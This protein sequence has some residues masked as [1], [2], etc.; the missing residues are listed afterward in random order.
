M[1]LAL[2]VKGLPQFCSPNLPAFF[3]PQHHHHNCCINFPTT[4]IAN[5]PS[6]YEKLSDND[7]KDECKRKKIVAYAKVTRPDMIV[8]L[9]DYDYHRQ[10]KKLSSKR[11][12]Y[13]HDDPQGERELE[14]INAENALRRTYTKNVWSS[15]IE[16]Y[17][18]K[19]KKA[20][21]GLKLNMERTEAA[22]QKALEDLAKRLE[23]HDLASMEDDSCIK[24]DSVD[25]SQATTSPQA[26]TL[27]PSIE[28]DSNKNK[29]Q[30]EGDVLGLESNTTPM[31]ENGDDKEEKGLFVTPDPESERLR[32]K[33][34]H[35][36]ISRRMLIRLDKS[37]SRSSASDPKAVLLISVRN[38]VVKRQ[39][40]LESLGDG[41]L[42]A[43][44]VREA[45]RGTQITET[46]I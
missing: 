45:S 18:D 25:Q 17:Q 32:K 5:M 10:L 31:A 41:L 44:S 38:L 2:K 36:K 1:N 29:G 24:N 6:S 23:E 8:S 3:L 7:L 37:R 20:Q 13:Y 39:E 12:S 34:L 43:T 27:L 14:Q 22:H 42:N 9:I 33:C 46:F 15:K 19:A 11:R 21:E 30:I 26:D 40:E 28:H 35:K 4:A 16:Y